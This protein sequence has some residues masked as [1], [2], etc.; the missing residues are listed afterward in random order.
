MQEHKANMAILGKE[1]ATALAAVESQQQRLTFQIF[2]A[3]VEG[4]RTYHER[5]A[6]ILGNIEAERC[7]QRTKNGGCSTCCSSHSHFREN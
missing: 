1:A 2:V 4:E 6:T 5:V 3:M 7:S